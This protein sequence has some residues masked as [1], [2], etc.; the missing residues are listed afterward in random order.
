MSRIEIVGCDT[1][2]RP[3]WILGL[4][5]KPI[6]L[7]KRSGVRVSLVGTE[8]GTWSQGRG[9]GLEVGWGWYRV[10]TTESSSAGDESG[11]T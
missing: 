9:L 2:R 5:R 3:F 8:D 7:S 11:F 4:L 6:L 10:G 1:A